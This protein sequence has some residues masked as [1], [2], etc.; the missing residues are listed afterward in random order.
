MIPIDQTIVDDKRGD[1]HRAVVASLFEL[2]LEQVPHFVLFDNANWFDI[3]FHFFY[4]LG[5]EYIDL[6][7]LKT[8]KLKLEDSINGYFDASVKSK[9]FKNKKHA[10]IIDIKGVVVHDPNPN[11]LWH[12][13]NVLE[14]GELCSWNIFKKHNDK[15]NFVEDNET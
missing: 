1:C 9:T 13:I 14:S 15:S 2:E 3:Y 8:H 11:K 7:K 6:G 4:A 5:Y 10:V 12:G